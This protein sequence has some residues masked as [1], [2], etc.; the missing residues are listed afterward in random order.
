[1]HLLW[2]TGIICLDILQVI[3]ISLSF[4][5]LND[6]HMLCHILKNSANQTNRYSDVKLNKFMSNFFID[7][8]NSKHWNVITSDALHC[9]HYRC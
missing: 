6:G 2:Y 1:M 8:K 5:G 4:N 3:Q 9:G 7:W